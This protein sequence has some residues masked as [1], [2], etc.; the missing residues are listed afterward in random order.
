[1][2]LIIKNMLKK[3]NINDFYF[4]RYIEGG[5]E[6][7]SLI[8]QIEP[9]DA[10]DLNQKKLIINLGFLYKKPLVEYVATNEDRISSLKAKKLARPYF[11]KFAIYCDELEEKNSP[12]KRVPGKVIIEEVNNSK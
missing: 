8:I 11:K 2:T 5:E 3:H 12:F 6:K 9:L 7:D 1:M 10:Y 4:V